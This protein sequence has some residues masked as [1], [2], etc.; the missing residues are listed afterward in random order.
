MIHFKRTQPCK[1]VTIEKYML[2]CQ[3]KKLSGKAVRHCRFGA[4]LI[5]WYNNVKYVPYILQMPIQLRIILLESNSY[6]VA[7]KYRN[8]FLWL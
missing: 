6:K 4:S 7:G 8:I 5:E 1:G 2:F 3:D